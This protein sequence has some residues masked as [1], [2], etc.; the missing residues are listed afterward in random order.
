MAER[1]QHPYGTFCWVDL[2]TTDMDAA[3]A[4]YGALLGWRRDDQDTQGGPPYAN[5]HLRDETV[6]GMG[7][8][9]AE[10]EAAGVPP[11]WN[12]YIRVD[13][14]E[15]VTA[16]V[17][18]LGGAVVMPALQILD[19]GTMAIFTDPQGAAF[20]VWKPLQHLGVERRDE[21]GALSW[22]EVVTRDVEGAQAFYAEVFGW[23][24]ARAET[25]GTPYTLVRVGDRDVGGIIPMAAGSAGEP[26]HLR[27]HFGVADLAAAVANAARTGGRVL[28]APTT[29][30]VGTFSVV[31][32]PQGATFTL[33][34]ASPP[35]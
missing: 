32:D 29:M 13:D 6:A 4:W 1:T 2:S 33:F 26:P 3:A 22:C 27:I 14:I 15:V 34:E 23:T 20:C 19:A 7:K 18:R 21:P 8:R 10:L 35:G 9:T 5:F 16:A 28:V 11:M 24:Y 12:A 17:T 30:P 31:A 25:G